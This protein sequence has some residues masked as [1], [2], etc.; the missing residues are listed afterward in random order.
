MCTAFTILKFSEII[1]KEQSDLGLHHLL[2]S[3]FPNIRIN[4]LNIV[5]AF[6]SS[7]LS[8]GVT[9]IKSENYSSLS[10]DL[11]SLISLIGL[12]T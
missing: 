4:T 2:G 11:S 9:H 6:S 5:L 7:F 12:M 3:I 1:Q 8:L 10:V